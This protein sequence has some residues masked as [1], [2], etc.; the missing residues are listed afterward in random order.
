MLRHWRLLLV[1]GKGQK[2]MGIGTM[3]T[4]TMQDITFMFGMA[5]K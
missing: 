5:E 1:G 2:C 3:H 4:T